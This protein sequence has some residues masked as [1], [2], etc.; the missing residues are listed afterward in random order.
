MS[1]VSAFKPYKQTQL[2]NLNIERHRTIVKLKNSAFTRIEP[3]IN[4]T[5]LH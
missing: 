3:K 5:D 2:E 1:H 4:E